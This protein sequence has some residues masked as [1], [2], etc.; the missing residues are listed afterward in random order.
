MAGKFIPLLVERRDPQFGTGHIRT[1]PGPTT[2]TRT[3]LVNLVQNLAKSIL[4]LV[5]PV[6]NLVTWSDLCK[7]LLIWSNLYRFK[8]STHGTQPHIQYGTVLLY[9]QSQ[10]TSHTRW[11]RGHHARTQLRQD[12]RYSLLT[13]YIMH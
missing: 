11:H 12:G 1:G 8:H 9:T 4:D 5:K 13:S 2:P 6:P 3:N 10:V 7:I